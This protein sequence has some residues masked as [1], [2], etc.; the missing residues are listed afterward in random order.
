MTTRPTR[1]RSSCRI[2][3][4][5]NQ[6]VTLSGLTAN[7][8][9]HFRVALR[10]GAGGSVSYSGA[11]QQFGTGT[12]LGGPSAPSS[13]LVTVAPAGAAR[14]RLTGAQTHG[15]WPRAA[16]GTG[17]GGT[18]IEHRRGHLAHEVGGHR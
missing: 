8:V 4:V 3:A 14:L 1:L 10:F 5:T 17:A 18:G 9:Y 11:D 13:P 2:R 15:C 6:S 12:A 16:R 7:T